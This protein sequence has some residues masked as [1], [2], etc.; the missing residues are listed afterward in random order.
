VLVEAEEHTL[1][2]AV[3]MAALEDAAIVVPAA[4]LAVVA[5]VD[6]LALAVKVVEHLVAMRM[7]HLVLAVGAAAEAVVKIPELP[8]LQRAA[9]ALV[10]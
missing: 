3:A 9:A 8:V 5:L 6:I 2:T 10:F 7:E 4:V 1:V